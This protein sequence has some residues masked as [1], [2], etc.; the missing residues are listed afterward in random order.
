MS[1]A[2]E[3]PEALASRDSRK[4]VTVVFCDVTGSTAMGE[5]L[6]PESLGKVMGRYFQTMRSE[7]ERTGERSKS[8]SGTR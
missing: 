1:C 4:T 3:L 2:T 8:S 5:R 7:I 6:D